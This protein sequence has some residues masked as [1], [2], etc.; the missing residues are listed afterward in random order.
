[1]KSNGIPTTA[2]PHANGRSQPH[3]LIFGS[4]GYL[5][6]AFRRLYPQAVAPEAD[7]ADP[8]AVR[9]ILGE[10]RPEVVINCAGRCGSPNVDWCEDHKQETL[11]SNVLGPLVLLEETTRAGAYFV[12]LSSGCVYTGDNGGSGFAEDDPPNFAGSF[13]SRTKAWSEQTLRELPVLQ[14]R[15]RM[16]F[17]GSTSERNLL[18]KLRRYS[19]VLTEMNSLTHLPDFLSAAERL[20]Q[21]RALGVYNVVNPGAISP[22]ELMQMYREIVDPAHAFEPLAT[23]RLGEVVRAGRSSC[24]LNTARLEAEGI[25]L[26]PVRQAAESA[27]R[28]LARELAVPGA[29]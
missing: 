13:Y 15:L 17:D 5:G 7:V 19:R 22:C 28:T 25:R 27:L 21:K 1:M 8:T 26:P 3:V 2:T 23:D 6:Q 4:R 24:L 20:I 9:R 12:H 16:P 11:R 29:A 10:Q 14:L 18:M